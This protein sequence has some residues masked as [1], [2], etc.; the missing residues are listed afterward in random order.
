[1]EDK[2]RQMPRSMERAR[3]PALRS[4]RC[5]EHR[6]RPFVAWLI[7]SMVGCAYDFDKFAPE[8]LIDGAQV[9]S[10]ADAQQEVRDQGHLSPVD[11][12]AIEVPLDGTIGINAEAG[13]PDSDSITD[14][15]V[16]NDR[17]VTCLD[18]GGATDGSASSCPSQKPADGEA[19]GIQMR[20]CRYGRIVCSC[21][22]AWTC[23]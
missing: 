22:C 1:M 13:T 14:V 17:N 15:A 16:T 21:S 3:K 2:S 4:G 23:K 20:S 18:S 9:S 7:S 8:A 6:T 12:S 11:A 19:C 10:G 5:V